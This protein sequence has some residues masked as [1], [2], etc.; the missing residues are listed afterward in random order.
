L[1]TPQQVSGQRFVVALET[2]PLAGMWKTRIFTA[3]WRPIAK[4]SRFSGVFSGFS[5]AFSKRLGYSA[6]RPGFSA[7]KRGESA[8][9]LEHFGVTKKIQEDKNTRWQP[10]Q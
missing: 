1:L 9:G 3:F 8:A 10:S 4:K 7:H 5:L 6:H 2:P